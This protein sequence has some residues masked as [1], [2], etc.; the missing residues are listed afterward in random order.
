MSVCLLDLF[1][2]FSLRW[3]SFSREF[4]LNDAPGRGYTWSLQPRCGTVGRAGDPSISYAAFT[5]FSLPLSDLLP[6]T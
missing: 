4:S 1:F 5:Q 6:E 3:F 2:F